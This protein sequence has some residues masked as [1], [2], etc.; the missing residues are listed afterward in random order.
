M[1]SDI[2]IC[3]NALLM[4]GSKPIASFDES[5]APANLDRARL[6]ANLYP[7]VK[8][9]V[10]RSHPWNCA[11]ARVQLSPDSTPPAFGFTN[12]FLLPG[13][14]LRTLAVG[15]GYRITYR[16]EGRYLL[17]DESVFPLVYLRDAP[18]GDFD[19]LLTQAMTLAM[20]VRLAYP[21]TESSAVEQARYSELQALMKTA[22]AVDG[23]D[24]PPET[25]GDSVLLT[26]RFGNG[27]AFDRS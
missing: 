18:E 5:S 27:F 24:D 13:D 1:A 4:L 16:S 9:S 23:Q 3:S 7:T 11:I 10:L 2:D 19:A 20:A 17:S 8:L 15:D 12:R 14:W 26:S 22:R 25:L 6:C 21:I